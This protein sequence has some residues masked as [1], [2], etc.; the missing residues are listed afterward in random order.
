MQLSQKLEHLSSGKDRTEASLACSIR[1]SL[2]EEVFLSSEAMTPDSP[3]GCSRQPENLCHH[4][5][6]GALPS[7]ALPCSSGAV[8]TQPAAAI[9]HK[10]AGERSTRRSLLSKVQRQVQCKTAHE[11]VG[12][13]GMTPFITLPD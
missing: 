12:V 5:Q 13:E 8:F 3:S 10:A 2:Q 7:R 4:S 1:A 11:H 6:Q 9:A